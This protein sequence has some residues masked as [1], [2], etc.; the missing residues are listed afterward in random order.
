[1]WPSQVEAWFVPW[2]SPRSSKGG[3][4]FPPRPGKPTEGKEWTNGH[5]LRGLVCTKCPGLQIH[6]S[7]QHTEEDQGL[8]GGVQRETG[9]HHIFSRVY[10][11]NRRFETGGGWN[12]PSLSPDR[13]RRDSTGKTW[14]AGELGHSLTSRHA[15]ETLAG[16][17]RVGVSRSH[18]LRFAVVNLT[19]VARLRRQLACVGAWHQSRRLTAPCVIT[20][21]GVGGGASWMQGF[22]WGLEKALEL[23]RGSGGHLL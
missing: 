1:M 6:R 2:N 3:G 5:V 15:L 16:C 10:L 4:P 18:L 9:A 11:N 23:D 17:W 7:E 22:L 19:V 12:A 13:S 20:I 8:A 14:K 21:T